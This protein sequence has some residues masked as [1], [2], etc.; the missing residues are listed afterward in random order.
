MTDLLQQARQSTNGKSK[1]MWTP[2]ETVALVIF[3][4]QGKT[5]KEIAQLVNHPE[6]SVNY[7]FGRYCAQFENTEALL[8]K[9]GLA[10]KTIEEL[11][12]IAESFI[13][14]PVEQAS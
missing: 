10:G 12:A 9:I 5:V 1:K 8:N 11:E 7:R 4:S 6:N 13:T 14:E 3:K 2:E